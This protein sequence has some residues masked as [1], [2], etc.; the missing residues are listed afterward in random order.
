MIRTDHNSLQYLL[1]QKTLTTEQQK[2]IEKIT[3]YDM[4]ILHKKGKDNTVA[5][6]LSR[7]DEE[8]QV[9]AVSLIVPKWLDEIRM[10]YAKNQEVSSIINNLSQHPKFEWKND[11]LW[12]KGRIYLSPNSRFKSKV[13]QEAHDCPVVG[14]V[15]FLKTYYNA[16]QTFFWKG[17]NTNIQ[18][19]VAKCDIFQRNKNE[20]ISTPG[21]LHP[22]HI[23]NQKWEEI[24]MDFIDGLP[25]SEGKDKI[26]VV[27]DRLTKYAHFMGVKKID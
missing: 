13:L 3:A 14:H 16:R 7:K 21:L 26:L 19:Y 9:F 24:S 23:P 8:I 1:Q 20:N 5:D 2:W 12:Y 10:E 27:V 18:K 22:L 15:G 17:M 6:A 11:I 4:E 25:I